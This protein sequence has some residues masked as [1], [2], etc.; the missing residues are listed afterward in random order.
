MNVTV[1]PFLEKAHDEGI[2][3]GVEFEKEKTDHPGYQK[4]IGQPLFRQPLPSLHYFRQFF[5]KISDDYLHSLFHGDVSVQN[6]NR[7]FVNF[8]ER[9]VFVIGMDV[10]SDVES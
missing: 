4:H 9:V 6:F 8:P 5:I 3:E 2:D 10:E 1:L 7:F